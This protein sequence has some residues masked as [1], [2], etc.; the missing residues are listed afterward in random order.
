MVVRPGGLVPV[1]GV[2]LKGKASVNQS[3]VTGESMPV[4]RSEGDGIYSGTLVEL[5]AMEIKATAVGEDSTYGRIIRMVREAEERKAPIE[6]AADR[7][8]KYFTPIIL[9]IGVIVF[10]F[11]GDIL[12]VAALFVIACP[13][14]LTLATPTAVVASIGNAARKGILIRN[15]ESL[16]K[17]S[18]VDVLAMDK[19]GTI[20]M[21]RPEVV[22]VKGFGH[23]EAEV[24]K[25]SAAA[26]TRSEHPLARA[27]LRKADELGI[28][29]LDGTDFEV[30][31]GLGVRVGTT[32]GSITVGNEKMLSM[33]SVPFNDEAVKYLR[34]EGLDRTLI[35][36]AKDKEVIGVIQVSDALRPEA[37]DALI[38]V[39]AGHVKRTVMLTGDK[40]PV[41]ERIGEEI[42]V[43]EVASDLMPS[44]K[45]DYIEGLKARGLRVAMLGDGINDAPALATAD[46]GVAMGLTGTDVAIETAGIILATDDLRRVP[47][48]LRISKKTMRV[49]KQNLAFATAVNTIGVLL[50][51]YGL[52]PPLLAAVI[53]ESN[54]LIVMVNSLRLLRVE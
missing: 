1:D 14:A 2:V 46:V 47:K 15:G 30:R 12:R 13:C 11:T 37:R 16:E 7:Y 35:F 41:A 53:H 10:M 8:A 52:I 44:Q 38:E 20:T 19:T 39:K 17:L 3:S 27:I 40:E 36:V 49:I 51:V 43:D 6:R 22:E 54:A 18:D 50:S 23:Q 4:E 9:T 32:E 21:G 42:S 29:P 33:Y 25:L 26:E 45:V 28:T 5:G 48:L 34:E 24:L 31:P